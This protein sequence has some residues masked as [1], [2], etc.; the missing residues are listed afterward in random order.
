MAIRMIGLDGD[1]TLWHSE[2]YFAVTEERFRRLLDPW[3]PPDVVAERLLGRERA[4]LRIFGYGVKGFT[5]SMVETAIEASGGRIPA[6][7]IQQIIEWGKEMHDHP[8]ELLDGV[9]RTVRA[10]AAD[11][12]LLLVTKGDLFHQE[13]KVAASGLVEHFE[14]VEIVAEK[15]ART[16]RRAL[17]RHGVDPAEFV[18]VGNS[19]RSDVLPVLEIGGRAVHVPYGIT[20][21]HEVVEVR[22]AGVPAWWHAEAIADVPDLLASVARGEAATT[23]AAEG[24]LEA[25][26]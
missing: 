22:P 2:T 16:Y 17:A 26:G 8:V 3:L 12:R 20:W 1:D 4:N 7:S 23:P 21:G 25:A 11:H 6:S 10:L 15:D 24:P 13:S 19:V 5:I 18:M 9:E 14:G